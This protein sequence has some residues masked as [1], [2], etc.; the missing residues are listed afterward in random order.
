MKLQTP[1]RRAPLKR[2]LNRKPQPDNNNA[3]ARW[4]VRGR[5]TVP[6]T[7]ACLGSLLPMLLGVS[8]NLQGLSLKRL[9]F[10]SSAYIRPAELF[11]FMLSPKLFTASSF[12]LI[13]VTVA[14]G[15]AARWRVVF[16]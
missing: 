8:L 4:D 2:T 14:A 15:E 12:F 7:D 1:N 3:D 10:C 9:V 16:G 13:S 5:M 11:G 6:V